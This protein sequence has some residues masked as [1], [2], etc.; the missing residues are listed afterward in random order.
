MT[1]NIIVAFVL[2]FSASLLQTPAP[3]PQGAQTPAECLADVRSY[4]TKRQQELRPLT[5]DT[6]AKLTAERTAMAKACADKFD[7]QAV[8]VKDLPGLADLYAE[9]NQIDLANAAIGRALAVKNLPEADRATLLGQSIRLMLR[10]PKGD[11]RNARIE[12]VVDQLDALSAAALE[13]KIAAHIS[14]NGYYRG[15][16]IDAGIIKHST[17]LIGTGKTLSP[18]LRK[19]Y[20]PSIVSAYVNMA[21]AYAGQGKN[22]EAVALLRRA[23]AEWADLP[24]VASRT[25]PTLARY[26]I[27]GT[28]GA[29]ITA[30][31][32]LNAPAGTTSLDMKGQITLLEFSAHWCGPCKESYPGI[33]RLR[34]K[35]ESRGFRVV[36]AT[37]L[38]GYFGSERNL[39]PEAEFDRD[40]EYFAEH[41]L[42]VPIAVGDRVTATMKDGAVVYSPAPNP[43]DEAY[44]VGGIPQIQVID[45]QG[46]IRLIMVGYD[47]ANE[48][49]LARFIEKLLAEK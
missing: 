13:Q 20:G 35:Y 4:V 33:N 43:N 42:N 8:A 12:K 10:E 2:A 37:Q 16:D 5:S 6:S 11:E 28:P 30:P 46:R 17:W 34:A 32:W 49:A 19:K 18:E 22:D 41:G 36:L 25:E 3:A 24:N 38:Y 1:P 26:L 39:G 14:M 31:R 27:V 40:R 15:D 23:P 7:V 29:A 9:V 48:P 45:R 47:D 44:K 21:E